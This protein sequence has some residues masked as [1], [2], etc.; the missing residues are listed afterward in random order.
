MT[1]DRTEV[2]QSNA[3]G[4]DEL[5][6]TLTD[7][8]E[9][10]MPGGTKRVNPVDEILPVG[11]MFAYGLQ[12]VL[13]MYAAAVAVP[14]II[15][16]G[17]GLSTE[18]LTC[19]INADLMAAGIATLIQT[20]GVWK[21]GARIPMI[22]GVSFASVA[23]MLVIGREF[24]LTAIFGAVIVAG[25]IGFLISPYFSKLIRFF[26][27]VVT[28]TIITLIGISLLPVAVRWAGGGNPNSADFA[29]LH[30]LGLAIITLAIVVLEYRVFKGFISNLSILIGLMGGTMVAYFMGY[31]DFSAVGH[32]DWVGIVPP[33]YFGFP[34]FEW[35]AILS[36]L[37]VMLVIMVETTGDCI[38]IGEIV[39]RKI[40]KPHLAACLRADGIS[41]ALAGV[42]NTF[43]HSAFAQNVGLVAVTGIK[44]RYVVACSGIILLVLG[45]FPKMGALI[46]SIPSAVLGG[47]GLAMFGMII[48]SGI[49]ALGKVS[50]EG[51]YNL[52][53]VAVSISVG[54]ITLVYPSFFARF[55]EWAQTVM[56]SGITLGSLVAVLMNVLLNGSEGHPSDRPD[57][58]K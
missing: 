2:V 17:L 43:P 45:L 7:E 6:E 51:N 28:G 39:G 58:I 25:L 16:Q 57:K 32:A 56:H 4:V 21:I 22:Q 49:R 3:V 36:M 20:L 18:L 30:N 34:R 8:V 47:A 52:M 37:I 31:T 33:L 44:S 38:A 48:A 26:P 9:V 5:T 53:I 29:S 42:L 24:G 55:P 10:T 19:L 14:I 15:A 27:P 23:P 54:M 1:T 13:A 40:N 41:T 35:S 46:A 50:F 12:H 11:Q